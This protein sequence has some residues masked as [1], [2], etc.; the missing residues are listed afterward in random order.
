MRP[1]CLGCPG[2][3]RLERGNR[4][5]TFNRTICRAKLGLIPLPRLAIADSFTGT[6]FNRLRQ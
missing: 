2:N 5:E 1:L 6:G 4:T 3:E